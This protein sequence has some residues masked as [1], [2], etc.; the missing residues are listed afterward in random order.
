MHHQL[1]A[2]DSGLQ[3]V[4]SSITSCSYSNHCGMIYSKANNTAIRCLMRPVLLKKH[5]IR[6]VLQV[7]PRQR[8][9]VIMGGRPSS[10]D[11][12]HHNIGVGGVTSSE[13]SCNWRRGQKPTYIVGPG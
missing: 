11:N 9:Q 2:I 13:S 7:V 1:V 12:N 4:F 6:W 10:N 3:Y 5:R 8:V